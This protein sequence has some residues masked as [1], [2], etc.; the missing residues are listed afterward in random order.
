MRKAL[1]PFFILMILSTLAYAA[2]HGGATYHNDVQP[3]L[4][5]QCFA[6]H[7]DHAPALN[8]FDADQEKYKSRSLGPRMT[9]YEQV[10]TF[11]N[12]DD[13]GA[14]MRRLDDGANTSDGNPGN[15]YMYLGTTDEA[16]RENLSVFKDW[17]GHWTLKRQDD[18]SKEDMEKFSI[19]K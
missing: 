18:L 10:I 5:R 2:S 17:V 14:L 15:M 12:G 8:E 3:L 13:A 9:T 19:P 16:R 7:G 1:L 6:C 4:K 11:V